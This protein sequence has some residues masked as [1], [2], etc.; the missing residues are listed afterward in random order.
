VHK[1][2]CTSRMGNRPMRRCLYLAA[3]GGVRARGG[4]FRDFYGRLVG[5]G[6]AKKLALIAAR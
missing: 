4:P 5:R 3:F 2:F 6:K 1:L